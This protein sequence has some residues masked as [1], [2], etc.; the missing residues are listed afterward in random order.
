MADFDERSAPT[1]GVISLARREVILNH[2]ETGMS[3]RGAAVLAGFSLPTLKAEAEAD[4]AFARELEVAECLCQLWH[5]K[6][7]R[8]AKI[9]A[10]WQSS[11]WFLERKWPDEFGRPDGAPPPPDDS[12]KKQVQYRV[13]AARMTRAAPGKNGNGNGNGNGNH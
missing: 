11:A 12:K 3:R 13:V 2:I 5:L 8:D 7:M 6:N 4:P 9:R 10:E 1:T